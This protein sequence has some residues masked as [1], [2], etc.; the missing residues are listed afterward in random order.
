VLTSMPAAKKLPRGFGLVVESPKKRNRGLAKRLESQ[1]SAS[2]LTVGPLACES[3]SPVKL[4][5]LVNFGESQ[6]QELREGGLEPPRLSA[7]D[8]KS[9]ASANSAT[10]AC[11]R[12]RCHR[13]VAFYSS[14]ARSLQ[15]CHLPGKIG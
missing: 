4:K 1:T 15:A 12:I 11:C 9:G 13:G 7:P 2:R 5:G 10:L 3:T 6:R 8:P 14:R